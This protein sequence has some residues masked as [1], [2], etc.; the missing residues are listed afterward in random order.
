[1]P[2]SFELSNRFIYC[3]LVSTSSSKA[4]CSSLRRR[5][6][7]KSLSGGQIG[8]QNPS[9]SFDVGLMRKT[10]NCPVCLTPSFTPSLWM[11]AI[12]A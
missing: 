5:S 7:K 4:V 2:L 12:G 6:T 9:V 11:I 8:L 1:M 3:E 10:K